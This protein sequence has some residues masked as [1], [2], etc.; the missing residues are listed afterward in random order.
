MMM[1]MMVFLVLILIVVIDVVDG[2][3]TDVHCDADA[4]IFDDDG[5]NDDPGFEISF[6]FCE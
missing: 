6:I 5:F 2:V 4:V 1:I 3:K